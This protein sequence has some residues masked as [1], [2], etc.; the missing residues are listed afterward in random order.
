MFSIY[1]PKYTCPFCLSEM[2]TFHNIKTPTNRGS[3]GIQC[4]YATVIS[5][6]YVVISLFFSGTSYNG[7]LRRRSFSLWWCLYVINRKQLIVCNIH[8]LYH[9][10]Y[11]VT[12]SN[13]TNRHV[14]VHR[15]GQ[16]TFKATSVSM[17]YRVKY[18]GETIL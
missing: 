4:L 16:V 7:V 5:P 14:G 2:P 9:M 15:Q 1:P 3:M 18:L 12:K 11:I 10:K 6:K 8:I 17:S 13:I